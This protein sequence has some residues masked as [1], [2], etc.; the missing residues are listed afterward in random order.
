M[1][2]HTNLG[3][4]CMLSGELRRFLGVGWKF[5]IL[6]ILFHLLFVA[7]IFPVSN[8]LQVSES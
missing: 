8:R 2:Y 7:V 6:A 5:I 1:H 3:G 4:A